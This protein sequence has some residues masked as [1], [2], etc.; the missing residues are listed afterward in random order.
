MG[1]RPKIRFVS[2]ATG[3]EIIAVDFVVGYLAR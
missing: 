1:V 3:E 2:N